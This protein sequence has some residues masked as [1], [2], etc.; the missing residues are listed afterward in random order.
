MRCHKCIS[1]RNQGIA[2]TLIQ[3]PTAILRHFD[4]SRKADNDSDISPLSLPLLFSSE[5]S[6]HFSKEA[7]DSS[8]DSQDENVFSSMFCFQNTRN[9]EFKFCEAVKVD[10][11]NAKGIQTKEKNH[12]KTLSNS[13]S[14]VWALFEEIRLALNVYDSGDFPVKDPLEVHLTLFNG[15]KKT[16]NGYVFGAEDL[17]DDKYT[18]EHLNSFEIFESWCLFIHRSVHKTRLALLSEVIHTCITNLIQSP[19]TYCS[20]WDVLE[21]N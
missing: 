8:M 15:S 3:A 13:L 19:N 11:S 7:F 21:M 12:E 14:L 5:D 1:L 4:F 18:P 16:S 17:L 20:G 10:V 9:G 6:Y 2:A